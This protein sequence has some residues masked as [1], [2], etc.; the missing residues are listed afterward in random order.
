MLLTNGF[1]SRENKEHI[2]N[3]R[4]N[5]SRVFSLTNRFRIGD[6]RYTS[7][8]FGDRSYFYS[9][10]SIEPKLQYIYKN[11]FRA[12]L[13][14]SF[15]QANNAVEF[16]GESS[17]NIEVGT[18]MKYTKPQKGTLLIAAS[19]IN[20]DYQGETGTT[21]GYELLR[22]LQNGN[23]ATWRLSYQQTLANNI[24]VVLSYDGRKSED[25]PVIH[26]G[27]LVARYLF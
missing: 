13:K 16:G 18:E 20:V 23:N 22:G 8:F 24:Q 9:F 21:L 14:T 3:N 15:Y 19:Y 1:D 7:Q 27:R 10:W 25:A 12:D 4:I 6:K 5:L 17:K 26:I 11:K 2:L